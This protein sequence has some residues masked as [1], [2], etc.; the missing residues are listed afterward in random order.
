[1]STTTSRAATLDELRSAFGDLFAAERRLRGRDQSRTGGLSYAQMRTLFRIDEKDE[2][3]VGELARLAEVTPATIT[4]MLD[5]LER[6]G[7]VTRRRSEEDRRV[8]IVTLTD[9]GRSLLREKRKRW[10]AR[11]RTKLD[12]MDDVQLAAAAEAIRRMAAMFDES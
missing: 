8:V 11:W 6:H 9:E 10:R 3:T 2:T 5:G 1:M 7:I 4:G 12:D